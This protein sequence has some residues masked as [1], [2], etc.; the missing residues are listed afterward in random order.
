MGNSIVQRDTGSVAAV[1]SVDRALLVLEILAESGPTGITQLAEE[2]GVHKSTVSRLVAVLEGRG[3][4]E[5]G[6]NGKYQLGFAV[7]RLAGS[8][9]GVRDLGKASQRNCDE[10][11]ARLGETVNLA[12]LEDGRAINIVEAPGPAE[13]VLRSWVGQASP[14]HATSSGKALIAELNPLELRERLGG[15]L[16][17]FTA[18]TITDFTAL[19]E[20]L[21]HVREQGWAAAAEELELGLNA[22]AA[23]VRDNTTAIVAALCVSGPSYRMPQSALP[24]VA[25]EIVVSAREISL[26]LGY[27]SRR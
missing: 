3:F 23:P 17:R 25:Q 11:A 14:A 21:A 27:P 20:H 26:R 19:E 15:R 5:R 16:E 13:V 18:N 12:I 24:S 10:L 2:I 7:V 8:A 22:V 4:V 1:Q 9:S 6:T